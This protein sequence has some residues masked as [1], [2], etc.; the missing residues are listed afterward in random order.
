MSAT[1]P[2]CLPK[3]RV[4]GSIPTAPTKNPDDSAALALLAASHHRVRVSRKAGIRAGSGAWVPSDFAPVAV[5]IRAA[6]T[7]QQSI[8]LFSSGRNF[9]SSTLVLPA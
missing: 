5:A 1:A 9:S 3:S 7:Q 2:G 8:S 4:V 6:R